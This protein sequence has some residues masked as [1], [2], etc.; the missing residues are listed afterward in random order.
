MS[1]QACFPGTGEVKKEFERIDGELHAFMRK[2]EQLEAK[3][4]LCEDMKEQLEDVRT[5]GDDSCQAS[6]DEV[7]PVNLEQ[8]TLQIDSGRGEVMDFVQADVVRLEHEKQEAASR[9]KWML[10]ITQYFEK[11]NAEL[12][13]KISVLEAANAS[14][15]CS[16]HRLEEVERLNAE[17]G[18]R[19]SLSEERSQ[20][21]EQD[22]ANLMQRVQSLECNQVLSSISEEEA[23]ESMEE[24]I[25]QILLQ[26]HGIEKDLFEYKQLQAAMD[27]EC[28]RLVL[29]KQE[30]LA[31]AQEA[32]AALQS[33]L[34]ASKERAQQAEDA[35]NTLNS[36]KE[37]L[38]EKN[39]QLESE[40]R[41]AHNRGNGAAISIDHD[42][43]QERQLFL[44]PPPHGY[45]CASSNY[46]APIPPLP[47]MDG[48]ARIPTTHFNGS[49]TVPSVTTWPS[50]TPTKRGA[51]LS[52]SYSPS[53]LQTS[54][55]RPSTPNNYTIRQQGVAISF[56]P[57]STG[58]TQHSIGSV[59]NGFLLETPKSELLETPPKTLR[60]RNAS[61]GDAN[62]SLKGTC[63]RRTLS[64]NYYSPSSS[65]RHI[66][67]PGSPDLCKKQGR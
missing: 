40:L 24:R 5:L 49:L 4:F 51:E 23:D 37:S 22:N 12:K 43:L 46:G 38:L 16:P 14:G 3:S 21:L 1:D 35:F 64:Y 9:T 10:E 53:P 54:Y 25:Q 57:P 63:T 8:Q 29:E 65:S 36:V 7:A 13:S 41:S 18:A 62:Q 50:N 67:F 48:S 17:L 61:A 31:V 26:K 20:E 60:I 59:Q 27:N 28:G 44:T 19:L 66:P 42:S 34:Q 52:L 39:R 11:E 33:H 32:Q 55:V 56:S 45:Q 58:Q 2:L 6:K 47:T 15:S 30:A